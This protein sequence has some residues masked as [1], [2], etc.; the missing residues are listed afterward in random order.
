M[1]QID[2]YVLPDA[3][4]Q[5]HDK[6]RLLL[7]CRLAEKAYG[8][9]HQVYIHTDSQPLAEQVDDLLWT[10]K[11]NSF[12]PHALST[13]LQDDSTDAAVRQ[14]IIGWQPEPPADQRDVLINLGAEVPAF[15][16]RFT[17]VVEVVD[18]QPQA[19]A[20]SRSR[21]KTYRERG[22]QPSTHKL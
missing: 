22:Q 13:A 11:Q 9:G 20:A 16:E 6:G 14:V 4:Y 18:Q 2:F 19:L 21:F 17:R 8:L 10:F 7:A 1:P 5:G 15:F 3:Q 12:V